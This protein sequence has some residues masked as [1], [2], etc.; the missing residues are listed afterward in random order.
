ME[1]IL[2]SNKYEEMIRKEWEKFSLEEKLLPNIMLLG[3]TGCGKSSLINTIFKKDNL[4]EVNDV[5]RGTEGFKTY[6]G[7][8]YDIGANLIDSRGYEMEDGSGESFSNYQKSIQDKM[9]ENS[10][11][12]PLEKIHIIWYCISIASERIQPYDIEVLEMLQKQID[13]NNRVAVILT[14]CDEDD[15]DRCTFKCFENIIHD[16]V[17]HSIPIFGVSI[18]SELPLELEEMMNWSANK[19]DNADLKE[20]FIAS[21]VISL[22][23]KRKIAIDKIVGYAALAATAGLNPFPVSDAAILTPLQVTMSTHIIKIYGM[24]NY[25]SISKA[26]IGN[27]II[28]NLGKSLAGGL[29][30][31]VPVIGTIA[32][33][34]INAGVASL[35]TSALGFA[36]SEICYDSCKKILNGEYVD[37]SSI[38]DIG[39][40]Q[41]YFEQY[42]NNHEDDK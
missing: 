8:D 18:Y 37:M 15:E 21:Q 3:A 40:I 11:K 7:K 35:I 16:N 19:I 6:Y 5:Y 9:E 33:G 36:I 24:E 17:S 29:L 26:V 42:I 22:D 38:F 28:S 30:K 14:K 25:A 13:V 23:A 34:I 27:I 31:L 12:K 41:E 2:M 1:M 32:G 4:A 39:S 10:S 20:A